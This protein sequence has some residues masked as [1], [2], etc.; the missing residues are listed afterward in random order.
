MSW[1]GLT[2]MAKIEV[3]VGGEQ[4]PAVRE[5]FLESGA[6]GYTAVAGV[7]GF[8]H[9]GY[10]EGRLFFN[11]RASLSMLITVVPMERVE[12]LVAGVRRFLEDHP[13]VVF[14]S[15]TQVSRPHYFS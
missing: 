10:H 3:V 1:Q 5:L 14:V 15:E 8:G 9:H 12:P 4:V 2:P 7:S 6:T 13:G 11:D